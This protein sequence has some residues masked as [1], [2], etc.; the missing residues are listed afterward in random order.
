MDISNFCFAVVKSLRE[1]FSVSFKRPVT[2][3][4]FFFFFVCL[5]EDLS[6]DVETRGKRGQENE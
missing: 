3:F 5:F 2:N 1:H 4:D 6:R